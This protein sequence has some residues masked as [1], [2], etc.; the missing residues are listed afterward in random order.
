MRHFSL[1]MIM[2]LCSA[3]VVL[4]D[5]NST[6]SVGDTV[7]TMVSDQG[8]SVLYFNYSQQVGGTLALSIT[9]NSAPC[10]L[11]QAS[12]LLSDEIQT[13]PFGGVGNIQARG[14]NV[15]YSTIHQSG[16]LLLFTAPQTE[17]H[18]NA[19]LQLTY[20]SGDCVNTSTLYTVGFTSVDNRQ[21]PLVLG[22]TL[23]VL[24]IFAVLGC[25]I[26]SP[27][28]CGEFIC[29]LRVDTSSLCS[30]PTLGFHVPLQMGFIALIGIP[31]WLFAYKRYGIFESG[32]QDI[33][34]YNFEC[35]TMGYSVPAINS[36]FANLSLGIFGL[37]LLLIVFREHA[38][39]PICPV[40]STETPYMCWHFALMGQVASAMIAGSLVSMAWEVCPDENSAV[41]LV[42]AMTYTGALIAVFLMKCKRR[43]SSFK[44][45]M[46]GVYL[47]LA[48][49]LILM[50]FGD[51]AWST[52]SW[53][54][55]TVTVALAIYTLYYL[56]PLWLECLQSSK[57]EFC[58]GYRTPS[59]IPKKQ[60]LRVQCALWIFY[61]V[62]THLFFWSMLLN[63]VARPIDLHVHDGPWVCRCTLTF[64]CSIFSTLA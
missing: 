38:Q 42:D 30:P 33:C 32:A 31:S 40:C 10:G 44:T 15:A 51:H 25:L 28:E 13:L 58:Q 34:F 64:G 5:S 43:D 14:S 1:F 55:A 46:T 56:S 63:C 27:Q 37:A 19:S 9:A 49:F 47:R 8:P 23:G 18:T 20:V 48:A 57:P 7:T 41:S 12:V 6:S 17:A 22:L 50:L 59:G 54:R 35:A 61:A 24:F 62:S 52:Q 11:L 29:K 60:F 3:S 39:S 26:S 4:G 53:F 2:L 16:W 36:V 21:G 45:D